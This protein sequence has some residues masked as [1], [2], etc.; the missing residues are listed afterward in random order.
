MFNDISNIDIKGS[1]FETKTKLDFFNPC[2]SDKIKTVK[3]A[4]VYGRNGTGKSTI[5]RAF[6]KVAGEDISSIEVAKLYDKSN[7]EISL[8]E[9]EKSNICIFDEEFVD[10]NIKLQEDH[11]DTIVMLGEAAD[12]TGKIEAQEIKCNEAEA[13]YK[14]FQ[15]QKEQLEDIK[16]LISPKH[17]LNCISNALR[18]DDNW[19]GRDREINDLRHNS[20]VRDDTYKKFIKLKPETSKTDLIFEYKEKIG[21]LKAA[22]NGEGII[23]EAVPS[24]SEKYVYLNT[25]NII[26]ILAKTIEKPVLSEREKYLFSLLQEG[27]SEELSLRLK[28]FRN[29]ENRE[30]PYCLQ[31]L[32]LE[33]KESLSESIERVLTKVVEE[34]QSE[35]KESI[36]E[37]IQ[38]DLS[39]YK[40]LSGYECCIDTIKKLNDEIDKCNY[41]LESKIENPYNP[42][43]VDNLDITDLII[44]LIGELNNLENSRVEYNK[45]I[46]RTVPMVIELNRI[47]SEIAY[48]DIIED[49]RKYVKQEEECNKVK[50]LTAEYNTK[51]IEEKKALTSLEAKRENVNIAIDEINSCLKY[52][53]FS[54]DRLKI[55]YQNGTYKLLSHGKSV[56]PCDVSVGERNIIG[57]SY[58]FTSILEGKAKDKAYNEEYLIIIDDPISSYDLENKIGILSFIKYKMSQF[59]ESNKETKALILTHDLM[60]FYD[61]YKVFEEIVASCKLQGYK[62]QPKFNIFEMR[63]KTLKRFSYKRRQEYTELVKLIYNYASNQ[64]DSYEMVI[65]NIMR[66]VLEAFS[67]F[68]YK[69]GI[70]DVSTDNNILSILKDEEYISYFKN[71]MYRLVLHGGSH[72]EEQIKSMNDYNFFNL[73]SSE[74]KRRTA[75]DVLCFIYLLNKRHIIEHLG[76]SSKCELKLKEWC[77]EIKERSSVI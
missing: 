53:F 72:K 9:N 15:N 37:T 21:K 50:S 29:T 41:Y 44:E 57:L 63:D 71:L 73:I 48:Y 56:K 46:K 67:T 20:G 36:L 43:V 4:L 42:I 52:I 1:V 3:A 40:E 11:L 7:N 31:P 65:G 49:Y 17:I 6:R 51:Y 74:E 16:N 35:L 47:N 22:R 59:L 5:A 34:H 30:C 10:K 54:E 33:Y 2:E 12:L 13:L 68:E 8:S 39:K 28:F 70:E 62:N 18:G 76:E 38:L 25:N 26:R 60:T 75:R 69:K 32:T 27:K 61:L 77:A 45:K 24:L 64:D 14:R 55:V 66:Q 23:E 58:F 19:A